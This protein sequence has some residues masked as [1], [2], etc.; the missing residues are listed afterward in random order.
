MRWTHT[1][2]FEYFGTKPKNIQW[3]WSGRSDDG[4]VVAVTLWQDMFARRDGRF[5]YERPGFDPDEPDTRP[6]FYELMENLAHARDHLDGRF[7][8]IMAI[9]RD[10]NARPRRIK[11][12]FPSKMVMRLIHLDTTTGAFKAVAEDPR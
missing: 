6:G 1:R 12:C 5:V 8:V 10:L 4:C 7:N 11:E 2:T 9:A 3:S